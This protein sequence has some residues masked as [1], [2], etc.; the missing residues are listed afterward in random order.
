MAGASAYESYEM[1]AGNTLREAEGPGNENVL[2]RDAKSE[3]TTAQPC[4]IHWKWAEKLLLLNWLIKPLGEMSA[5]EYNRLIFEIS[6]RLDEL[7]VGRKLIVMCR[8]KVVPRSD[9]TMQDSF[10]LFV[11]LEEKGFLGPDHLDV[12]K[13]LLRGVKEWAFLE[14][15]E[16]FESRR[17][18]YYD[19]VEQ[20]I[21]ALDELNDVERLISICREKIPQEKHS[22]IRDARS[23]LKELESTNCLGINRLGIVKRILLQTEKNDLLATV[24]EFE[25]R[26]AREDKFER[27]K[28]MHRALV[29]DIC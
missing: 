7:N 20:I 25:Q 12:L 16:K 23:L 18:K 14:E 3:S 2:S 5:V 21:R 29:T 8:G 15:V 19:L 22:N 28:G 17:K 24:K 11:E 13:D 10:S 4:N 9:E 27:R 26:R 6:Q 1:L